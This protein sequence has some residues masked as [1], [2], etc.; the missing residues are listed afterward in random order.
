MQRHE[1]RCGCRGS[2]GRRSLF[3]LLRGRLFLGRAD[4]MC[5]A[6]QIFFNYAK[7]R[8]LLSEEVPLMISPEAALAPAPAASVA[9]APAAGLSAEI[10]AGP[11]TGLSSLGY[12]DNYGGCSRSGSL[13]FVAAVSGTAGV[14]TLIPRKEL[15]WGVVFVMDERCLRRLVILLVPQLL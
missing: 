15:F 11:A 3:L 14:R 9:A 12:V 10:A 1:R 4:V 13:T 6:A 5:I 8:A 7:R 2:T